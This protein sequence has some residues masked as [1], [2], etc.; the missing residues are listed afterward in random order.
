M[1][2]FSNVSNE[3]FEIGFYDMDGTWFRLW[4]RVWGEQTPEL[5]HGS[6]ELLARVDTG[7]GYVEVPFEEVCCN[8]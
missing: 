5:N 2:T 7:E 1:T 6:G 4:D 8:A 3:C